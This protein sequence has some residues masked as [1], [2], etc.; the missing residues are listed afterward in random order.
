MITALREQQTQQAQQKRPR[1]NHGMAKEEPHSIDSTLTER[2]QHPLITKHPAAEEPTIAST[3]KKRKF[4]RDDPAE[5]ETHAQPLPTPWRIPFP[6]KARWDLCP[7]PR[8]SRTTL[9]IF[10]QPAVLEERNGDI[11]YRVVNNDGARESII[12][13]TG[14]KCRTSNSSCLYSLSAASGALGSSFAPEL[15]PSLP[16]QETPG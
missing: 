12:I 4:S 9:T 11:Q 10:L 3:S 5:E 2:E 16:K 15:L 8:A 13:L 14:L 7:K 6:D 1:Q